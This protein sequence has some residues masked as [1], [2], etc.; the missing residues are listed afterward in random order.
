MLRST[1]IKE[2]NNSP[3][4]NVRLIQFSQFALLKGFHNTVRHFQVHKYFS[5]HHQNP[6]HTYPCVPIQK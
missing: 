6:S 5:L 1:K 2:Q 4:L 3:T